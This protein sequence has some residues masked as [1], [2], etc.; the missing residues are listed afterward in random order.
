MDSGEDFDVNSLAGELGGLTKAEPVVTE[1]E[2]GK[3]NGGDDGADETKDSDPNNHT[4]GFPSKKDGKESQ[5]QDS[6]EEDSDDDDEDFFSLFKKEI[7]Y[8]GDIEDKTG[9][10]IIN[11]AKAVIESTREELKV[12]DNP[13]IKGFADH[14]LAGGSPETY[15]NVPQISTYFKDLTIAED[16]VEKMESFLEW[17]LE[18]RGNDKEDIDIIIKNKKENGKLGD[19]FEKELKYRR[20]AE[21]KS[22]EELQ[23]AQ[24]EATDNELK[25]AKKYFDEQTAYYDSLKGIVVDKEIAGKIKEIALPDKKTGIAPLMDIFNNLSPTDHAKLNIF[26]YALSQGKPFTYQPNKVVKEQVKDRPIDSILK[27]ATSTKGKTEIGNLADLE[28]KLNFSI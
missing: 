7:G 4:G 25:E 27:S 17:S 21:E 24:Q 14:I 9:S 5:S 28:K 11:I 1:D 20:D 18:Q 2:D 8:E 12:L 19:F 23:K 10:G 13:I 16:E 26:A 22:N 6:K 15:K 3:D